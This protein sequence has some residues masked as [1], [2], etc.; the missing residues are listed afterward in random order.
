[1]EAEC[2][3]TRMA[4]DL[5]EVR[6]LLQVESDE[7][8]VLKVAL[9]LVYDDLQV[10]QAEGT[11][12]LAAHAIDITTQVSQL[13]KEALRSGITQAFAIAYS[14]YVDSIDLEIM[15]LGFMPGDEASE[16]DE[17]EAAMAPLAQNLVNRVEDIVLPGGDS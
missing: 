9:G 2:V 3:A 8:D 12:S 6:S 5:A 10:V 15:S 4:T 7:L 14:H 1:M 16:L 11:S 17:I 13:E